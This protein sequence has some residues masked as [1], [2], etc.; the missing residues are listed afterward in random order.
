MESVSCTNLSSVIKRQ[1]MSKTCTGRMVWKEDTS[2]LEA[3][4]T[5]RKPKEKT[6][7]AFHGRLEATSAAYRIWVSTARRTVQWMRG[8]E[9][10]AADLAVLEVGRHQ[11]A[12]GQAQ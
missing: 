1:Y 2:K 9:R 11:T 3:A 7:Y 12:Q 6:E 10:I 5:P 8:L 4:T